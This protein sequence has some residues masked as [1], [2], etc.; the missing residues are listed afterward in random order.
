MV[1]EKQIKQWLKDG[2]ITQAQAKKMLA[3]STSYQKE[4]SSNKLIVAISTIG[5]ILLGIGAILFIASNWRA[6]PNIIKV[7]ILVGSTFG[8][9]YLGY[10]FKY[11]KQNLPKVGAS[12]IFLGALLF[13][14]T[15]FLIAQMYNIN[16]NNHTLLLIWLIGVLPLV[17]A[18]ASVPIA[19]LSCLLFYVWIGLF[20]FRN[21]DFSRAWGDFF[22]LPVLYLISGILLFGIGGLHYA[23]D[24]LKDIART[25]R[26]AGI[27]VVLLSLFLLT[28]RFF[29]GNYDKYHWNIREGA[30]ISTQ[31]TVGL[32]IF[33][34]LALIV[35]IIN[36][37][38]NITKS[39]TNILE[40]GISLGLFAIAL[41]FF[42]F[43]A[44]NNIYVVLFN[45]ILAGLIFT[46]LFI[47]YNRQD[48]KLVNM[49]MFWVSVL[50]VV[51]YFD[52][53]W[54]LMPRS[55]FFMVG[56]LILVLGGI[57]LE[58]KRRQLKSQFG[59]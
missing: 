36:L 54:D 24:K 45:L 18:F 57:A 38:F 27:K 25:Y 11:Q 28:F 51:R 39:E 43:P 59:A 21:I 37:F 10:L 26:I 16:A 44:T 20:V 8:A 17:Y 19:G 53:F 50:I 42:F 29:A 41:V 5:A 22:S 35:A 33:A 14:A 6:I 30:E 1:D 48:M 15:V 9:Y 58:R 7:L 56:G 32:V 31:F 4:Q 47:G 40:N 34:V 46:L 3:D 2:T 13:G 12:L 23:S 52:F 55:L 49:G